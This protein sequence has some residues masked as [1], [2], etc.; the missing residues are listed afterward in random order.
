MNFFKRAY[1]WP[2]IMALIVPAFCIVSCSGGQVRPE[3]AVIRNSLNSNRMV[4]KY[5]LKIAAGASGMQNAS[6]GPNEDYKIG[7]Q[8]LLDISVFEVKEMKEAVRVSGDGYIGMPLAGRIKAAGLTSAQLE[9]V[10]ERK[11]GPYLQKPIVS[12][13]IKEYKSQ[14]IPVLGAVRYP[15]TYYV[16][17]D[18]HL[19]DL[20]SMAGGLTNT[21]G[22]VC[23][24]EKAADSNHPQ[25]TVI[26]LADLLSKGNA[27]VN[28]PVRGGDIV[29][30][31]TAGIFF[32]DGAVVSPG[33]FH[34][35]G[36]TTLT[37]AI[38]LAKGFQFAAITD[39]IKIY[40]TTSGAKK[41]VI[42]VDYDAILKGK[43]PDIALMDR[44][45]VIVPKNGF[46]A[47]LRGLSTYVGFGPVGMGR[48]F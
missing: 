16:T 27:A 44:D 24:V 13:Y 47:F 36:K 1:R 41:K 10:I 37:Q 19:L 45:V 46:K 29:D 2:L 35:R 11:L 23:I 17:G 38:A 6:S 8:D 7:P 40:R 4:N 5:N 21:A 9:K 15:K 14:A 18:T 42:P 28:V 32:V 48:S 33:S 43:K 39:G 20:L 31:P 26:N 30:V 22:N 25:K 34:I 3:E 12:V